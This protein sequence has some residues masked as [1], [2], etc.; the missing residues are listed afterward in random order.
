VL[1]RR[2]ARTVLDQRVALP[3]ARSAALR[4]EPAFAR[5]MGV[6]QDALRRGAALA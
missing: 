4:A 6:L 2:P 5:T 1:S 3:A